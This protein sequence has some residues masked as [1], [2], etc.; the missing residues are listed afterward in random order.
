MRSDDEV[1]KILREV[2]AEM[3]KDP[4]EIMAVRSKGDSYFAKRA[5]GAVAAFPN[6]LIEDHLNSPSKEIEHQLHRILDSG[7][8]VLKK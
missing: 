8:H 4:G 6:Q 3:N 7:F 1:L 5:D 2:Y